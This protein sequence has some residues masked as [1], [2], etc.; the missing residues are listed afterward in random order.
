MTL[1]KKILSISASVI[2]LAG[3]FVGGIYTG[4]AHRPY[5]SQVVGITNI[6]APE[7]VSVDFD[8][9]WKVWKAID[10]R[11]PDAKNVSSQE[12]VYGAIEGLV[13]SLGDP[14]S[15]YFPPQES[16]EFD[17]T[18]NGSFDGIGMEIGIK[19]HTLTVVAALKNTPAE[20]AGLRAG[21]F[22]L[23]IGDTATTDMTID[24]AVRLIRGKKGTD[25]TL[26]VYRKGDTAPKNIVVTR[27]TISIPQIET[28][29]VGEDV[30]VISLYNFGANSAN[31]FAQAIA[32]FQKTG[33][34][35]MIIDLR[36]NPG[37][38]LDASVAIAGMFLPKGETIVTES[39]GDTQKDEVYRSKG[40]GFV[41]PKETKIVILVD[42]GSAS[43]SEILAGALQQHGAATLIGETTY[44]KGSVQ[45]VIDVTGDTM[46]KL[47]IAKWLTPNGTWISKKGIDPDIAVKIKD[48]DF[49]NG[50]DPVLARALQFFATGK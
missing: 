5:E 13:G 28:K 49:A 42:K 18:I 17:E 8:A 41:N 37:G 39:F 34:K 7:G 6:T 32:E 27:D 10:E 19:E 35:K 40:Y 45:E 15:V 3:V 29:Q 14:Y 20:R 16:K 31:Q 22:I 4:Y 26:N 48:G 43:A 23:K 50:K 9:F 21:D 47:T 36:S 2:L 30:F 46:L 44:G 11:Y 24:E 33:R 38:Y 1:K 25:V 12:R